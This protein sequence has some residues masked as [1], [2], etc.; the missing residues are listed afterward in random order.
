MGAASAATRLKTAIGMLGA[1]SAKAAQA[2][3]L[4]GGN[5]ATAAAILRSKGGAGLLS[6]LNAMTTGRVTGSTFASAFYGGGLGT[7]TGGTKG[8]GSG[9]GEYL[10][11]LGFTPAQANIMEGPGGIASFAKMTPTQLAAAG[12]ARGTTGSQAEQTVRSAIVGGM[13]GGGRSG[14]AIMQLMNEAGTATT[15]QAGIVAAENPKT[16]AQALALAFGEPTVTFNKFKAALENLTIS[17]GKDV[18]PALDDFM[19]TLLKIGKWFSNNKWALNAL[20]V[21]AGSL[22]AGAAVVKTVS[23]GEK[24]VTGTINIAKFLTGSG[25]LTTSGTSLTGAA[26][27]LGLAAGDL[28]TAA[29]MLMGKGGV[30][31][32]GGMTAAEEE[33]SAVS[34]G[35]IMARVA[36]PLIGVAVAYVLAK[37][38]SSKYGKYVPS[39]L[40]DQALEND[41][42]KLGN[43][44]KSLGLARDLHQPSIHVRVPNSAL[45]PAQR[46]VVTQMQSNSA[47]GGYVGA[48]HGV[49]TAFDARLAGVSGVTGASFSTT[50]LNAAAKKYAITADSLK[51]AADDQK[52]AAQQ[53]DTTITHLSSAAQSLDMVAQRLN[54]AADNAASAFSPGNI[55]ALNVAGT[56]T[57]DSA[58]VGS[59]AKQP[60]HP[61]A[62]GPLPLQRGTMPWGST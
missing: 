4:F 35:T 62:A 49:L 32:V 59:D 54:V 13:F 15:K 27:K 30:P 25:T 10:R 6:Y 19:G 33:G 37:Y 11:V 20:G 34:F 26:T 56:K 29:D 61:K 41:L 17:V 38:L 60:R 8:V 43:V 21:A 50:S 48:Q 52:T 45:T 46:V 55:H 18:T 7:T 24:M 31:G 40:H 1:P 58:E 14:A 36:G 3:E 42:S 5:I 28:S 51:T 53:T 57:S 2:F 23:V 44:A 9:A 22:V 12:F 47:A 16:Y 39:W